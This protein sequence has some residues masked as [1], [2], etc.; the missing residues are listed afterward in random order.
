MV[1]FVAS[2]KVYR[3][4]GSAAKIETV[5]L[6]D[7]G[8][9]DVRILGVRVLNPAA[10]RKALRINLFLAATGGAKQLRCSAEQTVYRQPVQQ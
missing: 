6:R 10:T 8:I 4:G 5:G 3:N 2:I 9:V 1:G 7:K